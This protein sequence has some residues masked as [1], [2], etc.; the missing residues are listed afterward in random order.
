MRVNEARVLSRAH[1]HTSS[2]GKRRGGTQDARLE[3]VAGPPQHTA[4]GLEPELSLSSLSFCAGRWCGHGE[5]EQEG[6][7]HVFALRGSRPF[8]GLSLQL[9]TEKSEGK[10]LGGKFLIVASLSTPPV[11]DS[12]A[13]SPLCTS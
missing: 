12:R 10:E 9:E 3:E 11:G 7:F 5:Y 1:I 13:S 2:S 4:S 8:L 6:R